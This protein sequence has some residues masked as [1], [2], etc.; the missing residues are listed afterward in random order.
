M[1]QIKN[2]KNLDINKKKIIEK[3]VHNQVEPNNYGKKQLIACVRIDFVIWLKYLIEKNYDLGV[4]KKFSTK[5]KKKTQTAIF[6]QKEVDLLCEIFGIQE[7]NIVQK[8]TTWDDVDHFFCK[9]CDYFFASK[10]ALMRHIERFHSSEKKFKCE[11]CLKIFGSKNGLS[12][13]RTVHIKVYQPISC[14]YC[15][16]TFRRNDTMLAHVRNFHKDIIAETHSRPSRV[17]KK[18]QANLDTSTPIIPAKKTPKK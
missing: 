17:R 18:S 6:S 11:I 7:S 8:L 16:S 9:K 12:R 13:H 3:I 2:F 4:P 10:Q 14:D 5:L 1:E 15:T